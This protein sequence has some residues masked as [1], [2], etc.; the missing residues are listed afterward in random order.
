MRAVNKRAFDL[1]PLRADA[2]R[3]LGLMIVRHKY[4]PRCSLAAR[5]IQNYRVTMLRQCWQ[6]ARGCIIRRA[7]VPRSPGRAPAVVKT[8]RRGPAHHLTA[9]ARDGL[10][11]IARTQVILESPDWAQGF[12]RSLA[13]QQRLGTVDIQRTRTYYIH[14]L[15]RR[16]DLSTA[17]RELLRT[18]AGDIE[19][20]LALGPAVFV[21]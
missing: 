1:E 16:G 3:H 5:K 9:G 13:I 8:A 10:E 20:I 11:H 18:P 6:R 2:L 4:L 15:L 7:S 21:G 12:G 19:F 14:G 17:R